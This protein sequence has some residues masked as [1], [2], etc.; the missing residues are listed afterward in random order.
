[1]NERDAATLARAYLATRTDEAR[2]ALARGLAASLGGTEVT[3]GAVVDALVRDLAGGG[4]LAL[5]AAEALASARPT[6]PAQTALL[7]AYARAEDVVRARLG[8]ALARFAPGAEV[9]ARDLADATSAPSVR[10]AAAWALAGVSGAR[11][12]LRAAVSS[13]EPPVAANARAALAVADGARPRRRWS[14]VRLVSAAGAPAADRW[15][16]VTAADGVAVWA[17]TDER[18]RARVAGLPDGA[19]SLRVGPAR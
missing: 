14:A 13:A 5:G 11:E 12:A 16:A 4:A 2:A 18:G 9:L 17:L 1:M 10:A 6:R 19:L 7:A 3:D 8:P 15:V